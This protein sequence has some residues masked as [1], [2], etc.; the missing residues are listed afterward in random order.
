LPV[1]VNGKV[2]DKIVVK[3]DATA[4]E[5]EAIALAAPKVAEHIAGKTIKK[6]VVV[7]GRLVNIVVA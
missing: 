3:R 5:I 2:R 6:V 7:P 1:Q 4:A